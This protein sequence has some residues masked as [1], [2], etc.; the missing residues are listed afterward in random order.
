MKKRILC[1]AFAFSLGGMLLLSCRPS[2][3]L[4]SSS[5]S[6]TG[7]ASSSSPSGSSAS[8]SSSYQ[9]SH[10]SEEVAGYLQDLAKTS[11]GSHLYLHYLRYDNTPS[12]YSDWDVWAWGYKPVSGEGAKFDWLGRTTSADLLSASGEAKVD[13]FG[14]AMIDINLTKKY[15]GGWNNA[16]KTMGGQSIGYTDASGTIDEQVG[17]Q[18]VKTST[19]SSSSFWVND[20]S[21]LFVS[22]ADYAFKN[23]DGTTSYHIFVLQDKVQ[24]PSA[25]PLVSIHDPFEGDDGKAVTYGNSAYSNVSLSDKALTATSPMFLK[26][27]AGGAVAK[28]GNAS[29]ESGAGVGYQIMVSSFA[30]SDGDGFGDLY[31]ID[32][33]LDYI[34]ALGVNVLW[35]TPIQMSDSYHG[36]DISDYTQVDPKFGSKLSPNAKEGKVN[37]ASAMEDYKLL[38]KDAHAKGMAVLMDLVLNHTSTSNIWFSKSAQL[39]KDYRGYYQWGNNQTQKDKISEGNYWYPYGDHVYSYYAKFGSGMPELNYSYQATR[40]AVIAMA[41]DWCSLG[42]DGFRM[43]A[44]KHIYMNDEATASSS[45]TVILDKSTSGGKTLDYSSNLTKNLNFWREL[46]SGVKSEYPNAFFV[47]ENFDGSAYHVAPFYEGFDS[48][49]DFYSYFN[50][51]SAAANARNSSIGAGVTSYDGAIPGTSYTANGDTD[52]NHGLSGSTA[53]IKYAGSWDLSSVLACENKYR[54]GGESV[55]SSTGFSFLNG[56]F[57]SNH[58]IARCLN[59]VAGS[60]DPT[61]IQAQGTID[62]NNYASYLQSATCVELAEILLPGC[63]WIYYGDELG[64][65]G[66]FASGITSGNDSYADLAYRQPMKWVESGKVGDGSM[67]TGY[68]ITGSGTSVGWDGVN[69]SSSVPSAAKASSSAHFEAIQDFAKLKASTPALIRGSYT[70]YGWDTAAQPQHVYNVVRSLGNSSYNIVINFSLSQSLESGNKTIAA[71]YGAVSTLGNGNTSIGPL[72][73][74]CFKLS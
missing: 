20:G 68:S 42:V 53:S 11:A 13:S 52:A 4:T 56:A 44:V 16:T 14:G 25:S 10:T 37:A 7:G 70:A 17:L 64:M 65:S 46:A 3:P 33:K 50:L 22:L 18:I 12:S 67:T 6:L 39:D 32:Q 55:S 43:D 62:E 2:A 66:N 29:L 72:S 51:T 69:A 35:L 31:G 40:D 74:V 21:N 27:T 63:S 28:G 26:G 41:K 48:L 60:G 49:F 9:N 73:A 24:N 23:T 19:R 71:S 36:Y 1:L 15:A 54:S 8:S 45:D 47:G 61:G 30:D 58:D 57:T 59:R 5:S 38:L 34:K